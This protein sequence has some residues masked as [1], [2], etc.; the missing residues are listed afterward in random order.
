MTSTE[1]V[2]PATGEFPWRKAGGVIGLVGLAVLAFLGIASGFI[3]P[4]EPG[5][6]NAGAPL[7]APSVLHY[8]GTDALGRDVWSETLYGL[9]VTMSNAGGGFIV[10]LAA[11]TILGFLTAHWLGRTG[12]VVRGG[13]EVLVAIPA[14]LLA[15]LF[16]ALLGQ[17][18]AAIAAGLAAAP[19]AFARAYDGAQKNLAAPYVMFARETGVDEVT[20][21]RRDLTCEVR[22]S[23]VPIAAR[24]FAA[25][26]ITLATMSFFGFGAIAP[27][28]DLGLMIAASQS[29]LPNAW[30]TALFP[31]TALALLIL[32][33]RLAAGL[34]GGER[35]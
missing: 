3:A 15:I 2:I 32:A 24:A 16:S 33:A 25:V 28:R 6:L 35:P 13:M 5:A 18:F 27:V 34:A 4:F 19:A 1:N 10:S 26:T 7:I 12:I 14:L 8:F 17:G 23:L 29:A 21:F 30:W 31:V 9:T 20:L 11:G 22:D